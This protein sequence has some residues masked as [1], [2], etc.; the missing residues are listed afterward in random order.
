MFFFIIL[1]QN[2]H[3]LGQ[4]VPSRGLPKDHTSGATEK[5]RVSEGMVLRPPVL[6]PPPAAVPATGGPE[7]CG[8]NQALALL[9]LMNR[10]TGAKSLEAKSCTTDEQLVGCD[11]SS[12]F[13]EDE[14]SI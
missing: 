1:H 7:N 11:C 3:L 8:A 9:S 2:H 12:M 5:A 13:D 4:L 6:G 14:I 10:Y